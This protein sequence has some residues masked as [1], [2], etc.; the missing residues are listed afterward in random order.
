MRI[1]Q[2]HIDKNIDII[3]VGLDIGYIAKKLGVTRQTIHH[4]RKGVR[5]C[6]YSQYKRM[7]KIVNDLLEEK[8]ARKFKGID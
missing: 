5:L 8:G 7:V 6:P 4:Y 3:L 2:I 1:K